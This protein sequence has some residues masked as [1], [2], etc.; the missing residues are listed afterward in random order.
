MTVIT[1]DPLIL[2]AVESK[3]HG[4]ADSMPLKI[5]SLAQFEQKIE[6]CIN[7]TTLSCL[8]K[9]ENTMDYKWQELESVN[10]F[11]NLRFKFKIVHYVVMTVVE[12]SQAC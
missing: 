4:K 6:K 7:Y 12:T 9:Q 2:Q 5:S 8:V 10:P 1:V 11:S 3:L